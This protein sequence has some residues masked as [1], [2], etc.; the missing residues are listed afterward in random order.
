M[1]TLGESIMFGLA[2]NPKKIK[3]NNTKYL[4]SIGV[5]VIDHLP[6]LDIT[7]PRRESDVAKRCLILA[8]ILQMHFGAP[9][10][11]VKDYLNENNLLD[12]IS[13]K[14]REII[15]K[16]YENLKDQ[17][18]TNLYWSIEAVWA[19]A[20][21]GSMHQELT[22]NT[23]VESSLSS[24]LPNFQEKESPNEFIK[25]FRIRSKKEI[26]KQVDIFYRAHWFA[27]DNDLN[28]KTS[29]SVDLDII[30]ERRKAL[31]WV[32]DREETWDEVSLNT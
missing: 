31:E 17:E 6:W 18:K 3:K 12:A 14:E 19:L 32:F 25:N 13:P 7:T 20:W 26:F 5:D 27:R 24:M 21:V 1:A 16:G 30:M 22:F 11:F 28:G 29:P 2:I 23:S 8:A 9:K 4:K 15:E 10:D